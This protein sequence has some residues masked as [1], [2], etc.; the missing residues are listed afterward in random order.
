MPRT[1]KNL[2]GSSLP[3]VHVQVVKTPKG[4]VNA[5]QPILNGNFL[6]VINVVTANVSHTKPNAHS[7]I[8]I[9]NPTL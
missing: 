8:P 1:E 5:H 9:M 4:K 2:E 3:M 6:V 7:K